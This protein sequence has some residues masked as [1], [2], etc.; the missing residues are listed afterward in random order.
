MESA[1]AA[2]QPP[3]QLIRAIGRWS[4]VALVVNSIIGSGVFGLPSTVA[5][6][7]G[8]FSPHAVLAAGA[9]MSVIIACFAEVASR[10]H[11]AGGPY[12]YA[13]VAF[14]RLMG[15]Q[16][17]WMLWLGAGLGARGD[18]RSYL[19]YTLVPIV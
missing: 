5:A 1:A 15:I 12:L 8:N 16:T 18:R 17:A 11:Q 6:L 10:F 4:L 2:A 13:R 3:R 9:G 19:G 14:G 7:I